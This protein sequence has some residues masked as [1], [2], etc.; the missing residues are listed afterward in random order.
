MAGAVL[1]TLN[2]CHDPAMV[3][4]LLRHSGVKLI[5]VDYEFLGHDFYTAKF[6][7]SED[8]EYV[9]REGPRIILGHYLS[10]RAWVPDFVPSKATIDRA[11]VWVRIHEFPAE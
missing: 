5:F 1:C 7:N 11:A 8:R 4:V 2:A 6:D 10:M 9:L 3:S